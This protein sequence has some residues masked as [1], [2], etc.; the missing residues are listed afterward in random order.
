MSSD[1]YVCVLNIFLES[2]KKEFPDWH[3]H[4]KWPIRKQ[5]STAIS[6]TSDTLKRFGG[7]ESG[8]VVS[9]KLSG[10]DGYISIKPYYRKRMGN[11][12][13]IFA[14]E[15]PSVKERLEGKI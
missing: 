7:L 5:N 14:V 2:K 8:K 6:F 13:H 12:L 3:M 1:A 4:H 11:D 10:D 9:V 15:V